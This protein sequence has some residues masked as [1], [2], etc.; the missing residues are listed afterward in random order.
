[1]QTWQKLSVT[2]V[3][4][5]LVIP[6]GLKITAASHAAVH[7]AANL[8]LTGDLAIYGEAIR[9]GAMMATEDLQQK[10]TNG[11]VFAFDWADNMGSARTA[12]TVL[13]RQ[14]L[15]QPDIYISGLKPQTMA[16]TEQISKKGT[17]HFAW[18]L[19]IAINRK[20]QNNFRTWINFKL[21]SDVFLAYIRSKHPKRV[22]IIYVNLPA[23]AEQYNQYIAPRLRSQGI[24]DT[25]I[26]PYESD[27][28]DFKDIAVRI[29]EFKPDLLILSGWATQL[30]GQVRAFRPFGLIKPGNTLACL[31]ML[32]A[33]KVL[34]P[35]EVDGIVVAAPQYLTQPNQERQQAWRKRF[36]ARY[37]KEP[38]YHSAF[39]YDMVLMIN[40]AALK[41]A[42]P[43]KP[44]EWIDKLRAAKVSG[45]TGALRF[46][47]DGSLVTIMEPA[48]YK[49][50]KLIALQQPQ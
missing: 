2:S 43:A 20:S 35:D 18:V 41:L 27:H 25:L 32:E 28:T 34:G 37:G 4:V 46:D 50:G 36:K 26:L 24:R 9:Q 47:D 48:T 45:V 38:T 44:A 22:A 30:V 23:P 17:P 3:A 49:S 14:Y 1:M 16:I 39:A 42:P 19:D 5:L 6:F 13:Q 29:K 7:I 8:P 33:A 15:Y 11:P 31:D 12:A 40:A 21:E 10:N